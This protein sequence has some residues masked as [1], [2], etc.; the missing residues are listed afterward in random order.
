MFT[1]GLVARERFFLLL[2]SVGRR[3]SKFP[4]SP[5]FFRSSNSTNEV[6]PAEDTPRDCEITR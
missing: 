1:N 3:F 5:S 6:V 2:S 4:V